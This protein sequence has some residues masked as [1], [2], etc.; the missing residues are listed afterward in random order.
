MKVFSEIQRDIFTDICPFDLTLKEKTGWINK[1]AGSDDL[2]LSCHLNSSPKRAEKGAM[3]FYYGGSQK[4]KEMAEKILDAY[5][6]ATGIKNTG[7]HPDTSSRFNRLGIVRDTR[8]WALLLEL[9][10]INNDLETV[11]KNGVKGI[12]AGLRAILGKAEDLPFADVDRSHP[13]FSAADWAKKRGIATGYGDGKLGVDEPLTVGRFL[14]F[15]RKYD[16]VQ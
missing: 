13:Y 7:V 4:S 12:L 8:G 6:R 15:L 10:S 5:C 11:K 9:G 1:K 2:V 16:K 14:A 3:I